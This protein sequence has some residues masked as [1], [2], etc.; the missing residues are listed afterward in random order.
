MALS[1][2]ET[3][4]DL[5]VTVE[6]AKTVDATTVMA[7]TMAAMEEDVAG[8]APSARF[9]TSGGM[10]RVTV[11]GAMIQSSAPATLH[12]HPPTSSTGTSTPVP[13]IT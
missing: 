11:V 3:D 12:R 4:R 9:V 10:T 8:G 6:V 5:A 1:K 7:A 13:P 2:E